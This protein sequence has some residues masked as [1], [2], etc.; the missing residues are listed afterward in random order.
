MQQRVLLL[1]LKT[2]SQLKLEPKR[3]QTVQLMWQAMDAEID[4]GSYA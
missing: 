1:L 4:S 3:I 2:N